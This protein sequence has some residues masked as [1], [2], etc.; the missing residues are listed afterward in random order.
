LQEIIRYLRQEKEI[1]DMQYELQI[2]ESKRLQQQLSHAQTQLDDVREKLEAERRSNASASEQA[3]SHSK[4]MQTIN[5]LNLFRESNS[6]L[7]NEARSAQEQLAR[8]IKEVEE[9]VMQLEPLKAKAREAEYELES[10]N[11]EVKLLQEDRDRWQKRTQD[12]MQKYDRVDP[13][14][15][16]ELRDQITKLQEERDAAVGEKAPLQAEID[17]IP[18]KIRLATEDLNKSWEERRQKLVEQSKSKVREVTQSNREKTAQLETA[19][20]EQNRLVA[21]LASVKEELEN[22]KKARDEAL[23][24]AK[25][26][27]DVSGE[28]EEGQVKEGGEDAVMTD[29]ERTTLEAQVKAAEEKAGAEAAHVATLEQ[30]VA[31]LNAKIETLNSQIVS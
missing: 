4:L 24:Q 17:N 21:E 10:K 12:I 14:E 13:A 31:A 25:E 7:R 29:S 6:S 26:A 28:T 5:E 22:T 18:E 20:N 3:T 30:D 23:Q 9:L 2:Q 8:K 15:L 16:Q 11:G 1:V 19:M 27:A